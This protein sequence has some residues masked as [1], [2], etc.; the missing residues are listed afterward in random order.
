MIALA[1]IL[2]VSASAEN[3]WVTCI[4]CGDKD[5]IDIHNIS[6]CNWQYH[7]S[8]DAQGY[9]CPKKTCNDQSKRWYAEDEKRA[10]EFA[11]E[12]V[13]EIKNS[14]ALQ[15]AVRNICKKEKYALL[16]L[17]GKPDKQIEFMKK[18]V[19]FCNKNKCHAEDIWY[20]FA[21]YA[22]FDA[23]KY[24][25]PDPADE[26]VY[27]ASK[28]QMEANAEKK[29]SSKK[30][31]TQAEML[32]N[33]FAGDIKI[34]PSQKNGPCALAV[35]RTKKDNQIRFVE[36]E[37]FAVG[38]VAAALA[39]DRKEVVAY[40]LKQTGGA[41]Y[42]FRWD[43]VNK[44][45]TM[46]GE[47]EYARTKIGEKIAAAEKSKKDAND[48]FDVEKI[49][50]QIKKL[51]KVLDGMVI[52]DVS[53]E[54]LS[55][56]ASGMTPQEAAEYLY[57]SKK[58]SVIDS[59]ADAYQELMEAQSKS[60]VEAEMY[61]SQ[62][63]A[64]IYGAILGGGTTKAV[65][66]LPSV[67]KSLNDYCAKASGEL[68]EWYKWREDLE[69]NWRAGVADKYMPP[70]VS[71]EITGQW[72]WKEG[73]LCDDYPGK[74]S[75]KNAFCWEVREKLTSA[76]H[77]GYLSKIAS[78]DPLTDTKKLGWEWTPGT[79]DVTRLGY[80]A[81]EKEGVFVWKPGTPDPARLG[82]I[83]GKKEGEWVLAPGFKKDKDGKV[84]WSAGLTDPARP[85]IV[86][87]KKMFCWLP[88][89]KHLWSDS[90]NKKAL[91]VDEEHKI[92][93]PIAQ[94]IIFGK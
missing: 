91:A 70:L 32:N 45:M 83:A 27:L 47:T 38:V 25:W 41:D 55:P 37:G 67:S 94:R 79:P 42:D 56:V 80:F 44:W 5:I 69:K 64:K 31:M 84:R 74:V 16:A 92:L 36:S 12:S 90:R 71:G 62:N 35:G 51:N 23:V 46:V 65:V 29:A 43:I 86:S 72:I 30:T 24:Y 19:A 61:A 85:G 49:D 20:V 78:Y 53:V 6:N 10:R 63:A 7:Q 54:T 4:V 33:F 87:T 17:R 2:A 68:G 26:K 11:A 1:A 8:R 15:K 52:P 82:M 48:K 3:K 73:V 14:K 77:P 66:A 39:N 50:K 13:A 34:R 22:D 75:E 40:L 59:G 28:K 88:D 57:N 9:I 18:L 21:G 76:R 58:W 60:S 89:D 93:H 81:G